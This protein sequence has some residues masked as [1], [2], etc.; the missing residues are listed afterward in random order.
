MEEAFT[1]LI[2]GE[3]EDTLEL[4]GG[5]GGVTKIAV[6][7][8]LKTGPVVD[9]VYG[10]DL[11]SAPQRRIWMDYVRVRKPKVIIMGPPCTAMGGW[12][13]INELRNPDK[14]AETFEVGIR[15][16]ELCMEIAKIQI[17][18]IWLNSGLL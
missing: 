10:Y 8:K 15:I 4:F 3:S 11:S 5:K 18:N 9:L 14:H 6:R 1:A 13:S 16:A 7:R 12:A 2:E 17:I